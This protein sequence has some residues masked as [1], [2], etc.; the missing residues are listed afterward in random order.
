DFFELPATT[1]I[2]THQYHTA[3]GQFARTHGSVVEHIAGHQHTR[4]DDVWTTATALA[5]LVFR[6]IVQELRAGRQGLLAVDVVFRIDAF[7]HELELQ[8]RGFSNQ[9]LRTCRILDTRQLH[10]NIAIALTLNDRFGN[11]ELI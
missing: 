11:T 10:E 3:V 6:H 5:G 2:E 1:L 4:L 8:H 9:L 7:T